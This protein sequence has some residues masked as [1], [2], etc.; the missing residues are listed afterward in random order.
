MFKK[1]VHHQ[2]IGEEIL[3][4]KRHDTSTVTFNNDDDIAKDSLGY[5]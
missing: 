2:T 5:Q 1:L 3:D 4:S